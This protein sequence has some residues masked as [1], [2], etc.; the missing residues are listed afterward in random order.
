MQTLA[1]AGLGF[2]GERDAE[3]A[4]AR[5]G[6]VGGLVVCEPAE[7]LFLRLGLFRVGLGVF[8]LLLGEEGGRLHDFVLD[9]RRL[10]GAQ[11]EIFLVGGD[12]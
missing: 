5:S 10:G 3:Q 7:E 1:A 4:L 12:A 11:V 6:L 8:D 2:F 9:G